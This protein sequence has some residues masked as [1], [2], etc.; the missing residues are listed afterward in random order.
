MV[1]TFD[2]LISD[3]S[4]IGNNNK[5]TKHVKFSNVDITTLQIPDKDKLERLEKLRAGWVPFLQFIPYRTL[6]YL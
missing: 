6:L 2:T 1:K 5:E 4:T 3:V